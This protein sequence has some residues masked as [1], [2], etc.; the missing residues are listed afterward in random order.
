MRSS[1]RASATDGYGASAVLAR[2]WKRRA[3]RLSLI[4]I[5]LL[6]ALALFANVLAPYDPNEQR[7]VVLGKENPPSVQHPFGTDNFARDVLSRTLHG[8]RVSLAVATLAVLLSAT[9]G[10]T[11]GLV[12]GYFGGRTDGIMMRLLDAMLSIPRLLL[13][14][15]VLALWAPAPLSALILM[16]GL[17]GW[18]AVSR[19]VRAEARSLRQRD[20]VMAAHA[21][22]ARPHEII[23][24]HLLPNVLAPVIVA[25]TLGIAN[26]IILEAGLSYLGIGTR[27]PTA[28]WGSILRDG[29]DA[30]GSAWWLMFFPGLA[31]VVTVLA[32]N[33]L[34]DALR[35]ALDPRQLPGASAIPSSEDADIQRELTPQ[36]A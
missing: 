32:F 12:A 21:L 22:G 10:L 31:I 3:A 33:T 6:Y 34:G 24:R 14:M 30:F 16:L 19:L 18:F 8:A 13:L 35:D 23:V 7:D 27:E 1:I 28:S 26:V 17:T 9:I 29:S 36:R 25:A 20:F 5:V 15:A 2:L 11:Y 4:F